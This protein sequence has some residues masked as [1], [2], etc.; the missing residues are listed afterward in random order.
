M[1]RAERKTLSLT[2]R[3][4]LA[5]SLVLAAFL[6]LTGAALD[7][8]FRD[9]TREAFRERLEARVYML[10]GATD[11]GA[12]GTLSMPE[13]LPEPRLSNPGSGAYAAIGAADSRSLWSS[14][15]SVG[16]QVAYPAAGAPGDAAFAELPLAGERTLL[17]LS[18]PVVWELDDGSELHLIFHAA[19]SKAAMDAQIGAF[20][21]TLWLSLGG[22]AILLLLAQVLVLMWSLAP[23]RRVAREVR[24]IEAGRRDVLAGNYPKE[25]RLLTENLN[26]LIQNNR[27]RLRRY[28]DALADLAHSLKTPLAVLRTTTEETPLPK[29]TAEALGQQVQRMDQTIEYQLQRAAASGRS[30]LASPVRVETVARRTADSLR[31]VY[32]DKAPQIDLD[33]ASEA[34]FMGDPGDLTEIVGNLLDNACKWARKQVRLVARNVVAG[35]AHRPRL[36]LE[37]EDDGPGISP[38][39]RRSVLERGVRA[40]TLAPGQGIGLAVVREMVEDV[41][42]GTLAIDRGPLGGARLR[43]EL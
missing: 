33:I 2:T 23:L 20:R 5:A 38:A 12:D 35:R 24:E 28:R 4:L 29:S 6:G 8:A 31:K 43:I 37:F 14:P 10:L 36:L 39:Q 1:R 15:S 32:R 7:E 42:Q 13:V 34:V 22:A 3:L 40:D 27:V 30:A 18:Y 19:E 11:V 17:A 16:L 41:Y 9:S 25:L 26:A 21:R